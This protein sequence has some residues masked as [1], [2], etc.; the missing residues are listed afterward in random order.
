MAGRKLDTIIDC[1][2]HRYPAIHDTEGNFMGY[3]NPVRKRP[4]VLG[5]ERARDMALNNLRWAFANEFKMQ[6]AAV[7]ILSVSTSV[8]VKNTTYEVAVYDRRNEVIIAYVRC[9]PRMLSKCTGMCEREGRVPV[10]NLVVWM[11]ESFY[12]V[13]EI[14][15][16]HKRS[17]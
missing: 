2:K 16:L 8:R 3:Y 9:W 14:Y 6:L 15:E 12:A 11:S 5:S 17:K 4:V 1:F 7:G 10:F 13:D